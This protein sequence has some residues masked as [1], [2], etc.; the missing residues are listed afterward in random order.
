MDLM[1]KT[2]KITRKL[3]D[4]F[5]GALNEIATFKKDVYAAK[6]FNR[7]VLAPNNI[8]AFLKGV[9]AA[10]NEKMTL[11]QFDGSVFVPNNNVSF[12]KNA[13]GAMNKKILSTYTILIVVLWLPTRL[14]LSKKMHMLL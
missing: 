5:V 13:Y 10:M 2:K 14:K 9:N 6:L 11:K 1:L 12:Y 3:F 7:R 8:G 4:S